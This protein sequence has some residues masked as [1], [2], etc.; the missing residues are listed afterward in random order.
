MTDCEKTEGLEREINEMKKIKVDE[1]VELAERVCN[2]HLN[3][4]KLH[5]SMYWIRDSIRAYCRSGDSYV[6]NVL[7]FLAE[8]LWFNGHLYDG[9]CISDLIKDIVS[10]KKRGLI[11]E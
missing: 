10:A 1:V 7:R 9:D 2:Q 6:L 8:T 11:E 5:L 4:L 3:P